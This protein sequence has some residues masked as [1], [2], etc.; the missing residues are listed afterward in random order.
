MYVCTYIHTYIHTY[1]CKESFMSIVDFIQTTEVL[2]FILMHT[3]I[4]KNT[5]RGTTSSGHMPNKSPHQFKI[6]TL[7]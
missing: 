4:I 6:T 7:D 5:P 1:T 3:Y 2:E